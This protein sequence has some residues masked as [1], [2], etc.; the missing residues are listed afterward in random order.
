MLRMNPF[1]NP[2]TLAKV[3]RMYLEDPPRLRQYSNDQLRTYQNMQLK[4]MVHYAYTVPM[5]HTKYKQKGITPS[6]IKGV[7]DISKL[8]LI[9]KDDIKNEFPKGVVPPSFV[10]NQGIVAQTGGTTGRALMVFFDFYTIAKAMLAVL[11]TVQEYG[12]NWRKT[13]MS[14]LVDLS[15]NSFENRYFLQTLFVSLKLFRMH[16]NIQVFDL[17]DKP[18]K[19]IKELEIFNPEFIIGYPHI[20][21]QLAF[22][23]SQGYGKHISPKWIMSGGSCFDTYSKRFV[24]DNFDTQLFDFYAATET[25][26]IAFE[27]PKGNYHVHSD[28]VFTEILRNG[29]EVIGDAPGSLIVTKLYG[30][31]TPLI[32]YSGLDDVVMPVSGKCSCGLS[33][34]LLKNIHGRKHH[35]IILPDGRRVLLSVLEKII[36]QVSYELNF[37]SLQRMQVIQHRRSL[38]ELKIAF[39]S[40]NKNFDDS[41]KRFLSTVQKRIQKL[42]GS[43][44]EVVVSEHKGFTKSDKYFV[45]KI[46][47][48]TFKDDLLIIT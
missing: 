46:R 12:V 39:F 47:S 17:F 14:V 36:G 28:L 34:R 21:I 6:D 48:S 9:T 15:E 11:R 2:L 20:L 42:F 35:S 8:P 32:R 31:G 3:L 25:G 4:K 38:I 30:V 27:C 33:G 10:Y 41:K 24:A 40:L 13:K 43:S 7:E 45:S 5:Y 44:V 23:K 1:L 16:Q 29:C 26:P 37:H 22:L 19:V 18:E